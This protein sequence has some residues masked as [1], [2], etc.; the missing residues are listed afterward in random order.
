M[1]SDAN[2]W[3]ED[4]SVTVRASDLPTALA[5]VAALPLSAWATEEVPG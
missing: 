1:H 5:K 4:G 2:W 3:S